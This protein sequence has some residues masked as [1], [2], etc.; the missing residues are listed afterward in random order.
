MKI[1][2]I[3]DFSNNYDEGLK[4]IAKN[5]FKYL[6]L[7][8]EVKTLN[9][10][11]ISAKTLLKL[12]NDFDIIHYFTSPTLSSFILLKLLALKSNNSKKIISAL[13]PD[14][15]TVIKNNI[16]RKIFGV[17]LKTD[18]LLYQANRD[19]LKDFGDKIIFLSNAVDV[20][21]F[22]PVETKEKVKLREKYGLATDKFTILHVGHI[23]KRRNLEV[24]SKIQD[25]DDNYQVVII[26]G[27]YLGI[28]SKIL[29]NLNKSGCRV[30][31]QYYPNI[32]E[33][34]ALADCYIFPVLW[35]DTINLPLTILEAMSSNLP[36]VAMNYPTFAN[37]NQEG[38]YLAKDVYEIL[39]K[40]KELKHDL[41]DGLKVKN[42]ENVLDYSW[43]KVVQRLV[44]IY[45]NC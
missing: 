5:F 31:I 6:S 21:K 14:F 2:L 1:L 23:S 26:S 4:N 11:N 12:D 28:D 38:L 25:I 9:I 42:R 27:E 3:G 15:S 36:V 43:K 18:I 24:L 17:F 30:F 40:I 34:Y 41:D 45:K 13:H 19:I 39:S 22:K 32:E 16:L 20:N 7:D 35:G 37:F 33:I 10:K 8:H 44:N 29:E